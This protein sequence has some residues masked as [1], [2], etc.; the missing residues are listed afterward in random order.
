M[1]C[2]TKSRLYSQ[3]SKSIGF[4]ALSAYTFTAYLSNIYDQCQYIL[5]NPTDRKR[6]SDLKGDLVHVERLVSELP[7]DIKPLFL[8]YMTRLRVM[9][10]VTEFTQ[11]QF[12]SIE[13]YH[14]QHPLYR[15]LL[16]KVTNN[17]FIDASRTFL[18]YVD[19][20]F[21]TLEGYPVND[22][23]IRAKFQY[24]GR[25][26]GSRP[27]RRYV[28]GFYDFWIRDNVEVFHDPVPPDLTMDFKHV[29]IVSEK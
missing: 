7:E 18:Q 16:G 11:R 19:I 24:Y 22:H 25:A 15:T 14:R 28:Q 6:Y 4:D 9:V 21:N 23:H 13:Q 1:F 2:F 5:R 3:L 10:E 8:K 17:L 27:L 20:Q 12:S 29:K 26:L